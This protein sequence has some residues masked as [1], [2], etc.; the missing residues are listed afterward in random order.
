MNKE[1][2]RPGTIKLG[3]KILYGNSEAKVIAIAEGYA[4]VRRKGCLPF[5]LSIK[6]LNK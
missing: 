5:V 1:L 6:E 3:S 2:K 4:M